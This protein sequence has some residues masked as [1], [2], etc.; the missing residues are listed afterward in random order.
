MILKILSPCLRVICLADSNKSGTD[1][2]FQYYRITKISIINSS[3][4][5][6]NKELLPVSSSSYFNVWSSKDIDN[7]EEENIDTND[8]D[9]IDS[10]IGITEFLSM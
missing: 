2:V 10:D 3:S 5:N 4:D 9:H 7:K 1:K 8:P 6:G